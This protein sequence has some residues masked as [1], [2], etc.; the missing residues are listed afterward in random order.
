MRTIKNREA[1]ATF[2]EAFPPTK[3]PTTDAGAQN[4]IRQKVRKL[5]RKQIRKSLTI[6]G[7]GEVAAVNCLHPTADGKILVSVIYYKLVF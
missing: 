2:R 5:R 7:L 1:V 6:G 3:K 4:G